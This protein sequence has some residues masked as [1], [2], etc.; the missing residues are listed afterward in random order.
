MKFLAT[1]AL[2]VAYVSA[3]P[4]DSIVQEDVK[5]LEARQ[6]ITRDELESGSSSACPRAILIFARAST[7]TGNMV[8]MAPSALRS[9]LL[10]GVGE[11]CWS[12]CCECA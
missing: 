4:V 8:S 7:E 11:H 5:L 1:L 10:I 12:V 2:A 3:L 6:L 9:K